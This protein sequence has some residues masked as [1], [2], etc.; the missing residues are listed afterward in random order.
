MYNLGSDEPAHKGRTQEGDMKS[1][2]AVPGGDNS[3]ASVFDAALAVAKRFDSH[4]VGLGAGTTAPVVIPWGEM[5]VAVPVEADRVLEQED[6]ERRQASRA[7]FEA[8][9]AGRGVPISGTPTA[10]GV[11]AEWREEQG[12][13]NAVVGSLGRV[14]DL[15]VVE[16]PDKLV[17]LA[18]ATLEDA[19]FESGRPVL[20]APP[21]PAPTLGDRIIIAWNGSSETAR[22]IGFA[23]PF[24]KQAKEIQVISVEGGMQPGPS[25]D[26]LARALTKNGFSASARH[27]DAR[28]RTVGEVFLAE[29][30]EMNADLMI[31][32][33]Y[34]Q[35]RLRQMIF[36]G[37]TRHI[38]MNAELPVLFA[39]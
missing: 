3:S 2:L 5:G 32:G 35:S 36:G 1:I 19:L 17:S 26:E 34:T 6:K 20:M 12:Q 8:F 13:Q 21:R 24:L 14:F 33:A 7:V 30:A 4:I 22:T 23:N 15:I 29:A 10:T 25:G 27:V 28:G 18:E 9:L 16:R 39:H 37:A 38:I 31:K 11:S